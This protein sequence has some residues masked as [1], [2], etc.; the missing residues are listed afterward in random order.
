MQATHPE[1]HQAGSSFGSTLAFQSQI[2]QGNFHGLTISQ[3][4]SSRETPAIADD[5]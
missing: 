4:R 5:A 2:L 3:A 1:V